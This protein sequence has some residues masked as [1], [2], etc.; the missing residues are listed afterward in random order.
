[1]GIQKAEKNKDQPDQPEILRWCKI[2][3]HPIFH[4]IDG[5]NKAKLQRYDKYCITIGVHL[6]G[7]RKLIQYW[8][9]ESKP[10]KVKEVYEGMSELT[11]ESIETQFLL[12]KCA[13]R[14][15]SVDSGMLEKD[16]ENED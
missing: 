4:N 13:I 5:V 16:D 12:Y 7:C 2:G 11:T 8:I 9:Q 14:L 6:M 3:L 15:G 10:L 1:M